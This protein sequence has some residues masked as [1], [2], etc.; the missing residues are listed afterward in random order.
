MTKDF[1]NQ[2]KFVFAHVVS[3]ES[4]EEEEMSAMVGD[5]QVRFNRN[6]VDG[7]KCLC[8]LGKTA[9]REEFE[10]FSDFEEDEYEEFGESE[11]VV[12]NNWLVKSPNEPAEGRRFII[13]HLNG[14]VW[15]ENRDAPVAL[16]E[17]IE[18]AARVGEDGK[19]ICPFN[20]GLEEQYGKCLELSEEKHLNDIDATFEHMKTLDGQRQTA[21]F[22]HDIRK[23]NEVDTRTE[24]EIAS[25]A[26][27]A[28]ENAVLPVQKL[29]AE[30]DTEWQLAV[31]NSMF[32]V[33][34]IRAI[35]AYL[36]KDRL[37]DFPID[38]VAMAMLPNIEKAKTL[39]SPS[40]PHQEIQSPFEG[41]TMMPGYK[42]SE[43]LEFTDG[44]TTV[45]VFGDQASQAFGGE[46]VYAY[47]YN[48]PPKQNL[49]L[50]AP[51]L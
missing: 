23:I 34:Q 47:A 48:A 40:F 37:G 2:P 32:R 29:N 51:G 30:T 6:D 28:R 13:D 4:N 19:L 18:T 27:T 46:A 36:M 41:G 39:L 16:S 17:F 1:S 15:I 43:V 35:F 21:A 14:E 31:E 24:D 50:P 49:E 10:T 22:F 38:Q 5:I 45:I 20:Y 25:I 33:P 12:Y 44:T 3:T 7:T 26:I 42:T 11:I 9:T 8:F